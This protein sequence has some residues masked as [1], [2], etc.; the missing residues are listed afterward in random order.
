MITAQAGNKDSWSYIWRNS[1][2]TTKNAYNVMIGQR[3][4]PE[5]FSWI[6]KSACQA[7][8][9]F[10]LWMVLLDRL[11]TRNLLARKNFNLPSYTC[12]TLQCSQEETSIHLFWECPFAMKCWYYICPQR[13]LHLSVM[14]A[15]Y[16]VGNKLNVPFAMEIIIAAA[17][18]L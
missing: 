15:F 8:H 3:H 10:F 7:K 18:G 4:T 11:N 1:Q 12:A 2:F 16:D 9:K 14:D 6:W 13:A 5:I 17:W